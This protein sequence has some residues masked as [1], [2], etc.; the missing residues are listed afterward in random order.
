M[1]ANSL[2]LTLYENCPKILQQFLYF[3]ENQQEISA[4]FSVV[5]FKYPAVAA[6]LP[7]G[8]F[9]ADVQGI[10]KMLWYNDAGFKRRD[11]TESWHGLVFPMH[12]T[13]RKF[14]AKLSFVG[15]GFG[16]MTRLLKK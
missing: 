12:Q 10:V 15:K 2:M 11:V 8:T 3:S 13:A 9:L 7:N 14:P 6:A 16:V 4:M 1:L 5:N